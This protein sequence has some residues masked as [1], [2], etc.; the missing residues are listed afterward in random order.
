ML[1]DADV[2]IASIALTKCLKLITGNVKHFNRFENL[3][4]EN[5]IK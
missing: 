3:V 5:W 4:V 2:L 1:P